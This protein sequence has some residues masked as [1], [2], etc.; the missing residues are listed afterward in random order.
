MRADECGHDDECPIKQNEQEHSANES[1]DHKDEC[2]VLRIMNEKCG[3]DGASQF[4]AREKAQ[5]CDC[6]FLKEQC[7]QCA[8]QAKN[9]SN[10]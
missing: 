6:N 3:S 1:A 10:G 4:A 2:R 8:D 5:N 9:E 7:E